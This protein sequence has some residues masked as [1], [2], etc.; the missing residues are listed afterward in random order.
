MPLGANGTSRQEP[1]QLVHTRGLFW[2]W[3][4][5]TNVKSFNVCWIPLCKSGQQQSPLGI[6]HREMKTEVHTDTGP[7]PPNT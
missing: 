5:G 4:R 6:D 7:Q 1:K 3:N 2:N